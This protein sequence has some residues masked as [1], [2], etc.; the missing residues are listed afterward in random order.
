MFLHCAAMDNNIVG[1]LDYCVYD[2]YSRNIWDSTKVII[3]KFE[4][5][6]T[7]PTF[8]TYIYSSV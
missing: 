3:V 5:K 4:Y 2:V 7:Q 8:T 1:T 6:N